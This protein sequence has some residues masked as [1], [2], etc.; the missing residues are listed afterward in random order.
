MKQ[1]IKNKLIEIGYT[2]KTDLE[3]ILDALP[4]QH[5]F[6]ARGVGKYELRIWYQEGKAFIGYQNFDGFDK[7][8]TFEQQENE[9]LADCGAKLL[10]KL[11]EQGII[12][13]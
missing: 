8:L 6:F 10:I 11:T 4:K 1:E 13:F 7:L 2:R 5:A 3:T 12:K 9:S